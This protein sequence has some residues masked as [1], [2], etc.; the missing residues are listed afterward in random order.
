M[1]GGIGHLTVM[2][3]PTVLRPV[4][5]DPVNEGA[6][7]GASV[8]GSFLRLPVLRAMVGPL[9]RAPPLRYLRMKRIL[10][11]GNVGTRRDLEKEAAHDP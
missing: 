4:R 3:G 10:H 8:A 5:T 7:S 11:P 2:V 1:A 9:I 6:I